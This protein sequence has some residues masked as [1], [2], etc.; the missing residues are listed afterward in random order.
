M[1]IEEYIKRY[2]MSSEVVNSRIDKIIKAIEKQNRIMEMRLN[3]FIRM[4]LKYTNKII[5]C[6]E[7]EHNPPTPFL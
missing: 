3:Y 5:H 4:D 6:P 7:T 2:R 1:D